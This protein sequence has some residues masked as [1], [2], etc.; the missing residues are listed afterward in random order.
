MKRSLT[1]FLRLWILSSCLYYADAKWY[2]GTLLDNAV[3]AITASEDGQTVFALV[4]GM[5]LASEDGGYSWARRM[6]HIPTCSALFYCGPPHEQYLLA[7]PNYRQDST[8]FFGRAG[9]IVRTTDGGKNWNPI[10]QNRFRDCTTKG[11]LSLSPSFGDG[12]NLMFVVG[13][14]LGS[15][16]DVHRLYRSLDG[17]DTFQ[18]IDLDPAL[19][20]GG[21]LYGCAALMS[22]S[23]EIHFLGT[24]S[25]YLLASLD[26]GVT[27]SKIF[28]VGE[29]ILQISGSS[30]HHTKIFD[31]GVDE[32]DLFILT[33]H[34]L[35][36]VSLE[37]RDDEGKLSVKSNRAL[38]E[39]ETH[40]FVQMLGHTSQ[41][42]LQVGQPSL[43]L[44]VMSSVSESHDVTI[45]YEDLDE[46][47]LTPLLVSPDYGD[48]WYQ[49]QI[50]KPR[51]PVDGFLWQDLQKKTFTGHYHPFE[52]RDAWGVPNKPIVYVGTNE[53]I[54]RSD[55][56]GQTF[57]YLNVLTGWITN[58]SVGPVD[59]QGNY[60]VD[61]CT[62]SRGC[63]G[64][65]IQI[66]P[67]DFSPGN[68]NQL[69]KV[70]HEWYSQE[71]LEEKQ[72]EG[73]PDESS[74]ALYHEITAVSPTYD[75]GSLVLRTTSRESNNERVERS[76]SNFD[77]PGFKTYCNLPALDGSK[78]TI[79]HSLHFSP[80]YAKDKS[81]FISG[82]NLGLLV[83]TNQGETFTLVWDAKDTSS[84][85]SKNHG[86]ISSVA[87]SPQFQ[88]DQTMAVLVPQAEFPFASVY[89]TQDKGATWQL[90]SQ[91]ETSEWIHLVA[92][93]SKNNEKVQFFAL[94]KLGILYVW[95]G[96]DREWQVL[97]QKGNS[98][99]GT[100]VEQYGYAHNGVVG[101]QGTLLA[102]LESGGIVKMKSF[103]PNNM[104]FDRADISIQSN[105]TET[106]TVPDMRFVFHGDELLRG[107]GDVVEFSPY[108]NQDNTIFA[109]SFYSL[110][111]SFDQGAIWHE[112]FRLPHNNHASLPIS[113][114]FEE[115]QKKGK[116]SSSSSKPYN[117]T[118]SNEQPIFSSPPI[119]SFGAEARYDPT[120]VFIAVPII[121]IVFL[122]LYYCRD[123]FTKKEN[124]KDPWP[125][126]QLRRKK[127]NEKSSKDKKKDGNGDDDSVAETARES[128][129]GFSEDCDLSS[130]TLSHVSSIFVG[131]RDPPGITPIQHH[132]YDDDLGL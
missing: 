97:E 64:G 57:K 58:L 118:A 103:D 119:F 66:T 82:A 120:P 124:T 34:Y 23:S 106:D 65:K 18:A 48:H 20:N 115:I 89:M 104:A 7:S 1:N 6:G 112:F 108:Y 63:L 95:T 53:G 99:A 50:A 4:R 113:P 84:E 100:N 129:L 54:F 107:V 90:I 26:R 116:L 61:F 52:Y 105:Y 128:E 55:D 96:K 24:E 32:Y 80:T 74:R 70:P 81:I 88:Q 5:I 13:K 132:S 71:A 44:F 51:E 16:E 36:Q 101:Y 85:G 114:N 10:G 30:H 93:M 25:G 46:P 38:L 59:G 130:V 87:I 11:R 69:L 94:N 79:V 83:S 98:L 102:A 27:W 43:D 75:K 111:V 29:P 91:P 72:G 110:Y 33:K 78:R 12:D 15:I 3:N 45:D 123:Y 127:G 39:H 31:I 73:T 42:L 62:F 86:T 125:L 60:M 68:E 56:R 19:G 92:I 117:A 41:S 35:V 67:E 9:G 122:S 77:Q 49:G 8:V 28:K 14:V 76:F 22:A 126:H 121:F 21:S 109:A 40:N 47:E 131:E 37:K 2:G 17:G